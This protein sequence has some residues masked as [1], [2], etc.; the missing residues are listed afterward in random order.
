MMLRTLLGLGA[1]LAAIFATPAAAAPAADPVAAFYKGRTVQVLIGFSPGGGY[2]IY[3]RTLARHMGKHIPGN[4]TMVPQNMPG[5]GTLKVA[6]Y[7]Y[8]VAPKNGTVMGTFARGIPMERLLGR[9]EG[10][11]FDATKFT[12]IGSVT[13]EPSVCVFWHQ[14]GIR[15][16]EDMKTKPWKVGGS[17]ITSDLDIYA[18]VLRNMFKLPG[19]LISGFPGGQEVLLS[20][21]RREV[22]GRCNW[23]WSSLISRD[24]YML[25]QKLINIPIQLGVEKNPDLPNVPLVLDLTDDP[26][27]KAALRLIFSRQVIARPFAAPPG[28]PADRAKALRDG[29][30]ATMKD[31]AF[32]AEAEKLQLEVR[33]QSGARVEQLIKEI[34]AYPPDVVKIAA[35]AI[36]NASR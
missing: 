13:D 20:M 27:E 12:W 3:A 36:Q 17:G 2:D 24:K 18:N 19:R 26:K 28:I 8:N 9:T 15:T 33:P 34:Y 14:S 25:D 1:A 35:S 21:Q 7:I 10:Q 23:S 6:N 16:W 31:P 4:P 5:A 29:F 32:L 11:Q 22:D 30:D